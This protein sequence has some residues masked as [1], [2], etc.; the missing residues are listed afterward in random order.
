MRVMALCVVRPKS[1]HMCIADCELVI[2]MNDHH[3]LHKW[4]K[5]NQA[6]LSS[7]KGKTTTTPEDK[8]RG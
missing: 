6:H 5:R 1:S 4:Q 2:V 7:Q 3:A 8:P